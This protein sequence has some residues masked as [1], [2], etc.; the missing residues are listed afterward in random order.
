MIPKVRAGCKQAQAC[1]MQKYQNF[2][3]K[4]GRQ[5]WPSNGATSQIAKRPYD[6]MAD[7][8]IWNIVQGGVKNQNAAGAAFA[9]SAGAGVPFDETFTD[10]NGGVQLLIF[11]NLIFFLGFL[12]FSDW[13]KGGFSILYPRPCPAPGPMPT[14]TKSQ[15]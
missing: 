10:S 9:D 6:L 8:W 2:L 11:L 7:Q 3:V 13:K 14:Q 5:C 15:L 4:A 12:V 1:Y